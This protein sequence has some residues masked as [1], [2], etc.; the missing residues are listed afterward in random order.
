MG[1]RVRTIFVGVLSLAAILG[2]FLLY[3]RFNETDKIDLTK[4]SRVAENIRDGNEYTLPGKLGRLGDVD[5][6]TVSKAKYKHLNENKELDRVFGFEELLAESGNRW[7]LKKPY[8]DLF[9]PRF[10]CKVAADRGELLVDDT[11]G[12]PSPKEGR[13]TGNV[14]IRIYSRGSGDIEKSTI[15][16][17]E[18]SF[19]SEES[20]FSSDG[21]V[22]FVSANAEMN[23][24]G[25]RLIYNNQDER[26]EYLRILHLDSL[27]LAKSKTD[28]FAEK[29]S[30]NK[31]VPV[32]GSKGKEQ[33]PEKQ[34]PEQK[35]GDYYR[36]IFSR[37]V[38]IDTS[39]QYVLAKERLSINNLFL[40]ESSRK[41]EGQEPDIS[42]EDTNA[43]TAGSEK[44]IAKYKESSASL[45][46][47]EK[48][49]YSS[50][51]DQQVVV[52]CDNGLMLTPVDAKSS[53]AGLQDSVN[54]PA[55][56]NLPEPF[57]ARTQRPKLVA[58]NIH[59][60][61][62]TGKT[63]LS[64]PL[65][66]SFYPNNVTQDQN[67]LSRLQKPVEVTAQR[68]AQ[69]L[70]G[71][72]QVFFDGDV[73]CTMVER[74]LDSLRSYTLTAPKLT[75]DLLQGRGESSAG[76]NLDIKHLTADGGTVRLAALEK[77]DDKLISGTELK[78]RR[79]DYEPSEKL[80]SA[81][82]PGVIKTHDSR[83][84]E[85]NSADKGLSFDKP[86]WAVVKGFETLKYFSKDNLVLVFGPSG[87]ML[88]IRYVPVVEGKYGRLVEAA[89]GNVKA[90]LQKGL[91][92]GKRLS[93]VEVT[94]GVMYKD[95]KNQFSGSKLFHDSDK[96]LITVRGD[97]SRPCQLNG[98]LVDGLRYNLKTGEIKAKLVGP[99]TL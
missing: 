4:R 55:D 94:E 93:T 76:P 19:I 34:V 7:T 39:Q 72:K 35:E 24:R 95:G 66:L 42:T 9:K 91:E 78:C 14:T 40:S 8:L 10:M 86:Y 70:P 65:R 44:E 61:A 43:S 81:T 54:N 50:G 80:F 79:F 77:S 30:A 1:I 51:R 67:S 32:A 71:S 2:L 60:F 83:G 59:H 31:D 56:N 5:I 11:P 46:E 16:L 22:C 53:Y 57:R 84:T 6:G 25:L 29:S 74:T 89:A 96:S 69:Y 20:K 85:P 62:P 13:L 90:V 64:G 41:N 21:P 15:Y 17:D 48:P 28:L 73:K 33:S 3:N 18:I 26:I 99:G 68:Q 47:A 92:G 97:E 45:I 12:G 36:L 49:E 27:R 87:E 98:T 52:K 63:V 38:F 82:G 58:E 37:N 88:D 23:G 75:L